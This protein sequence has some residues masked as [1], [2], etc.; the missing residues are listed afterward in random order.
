M[1]RKSAMKKAFAT[2]LTATLLLT[3]CTTV[4]DSAAS[5][6]SETE[7]TAS[8]MT[9]VET[10]ALFEKADQYPVFKVVIKGSF[11][12]SESEY[13]EN[14]IA[15]F[16]E[17][18]EVIVLKEYSFFSLVYTQDGLFGYVDCNN[19]VPTGE[20]K[21][22]DIDPSLVKISSR[23]DAVTALA[24]D[25]NAILPDDAVLNQSYPVTLIRSTDSN[26]QQELLPVLLGKNYKKTEDS[27]D[28]IQYE[29]TDPS[30]PNRYVWI[31]KSN[32]NLWFYDSMV[33][34]ERGGE[35]K[36]PSMNMTPE[37]SLPIAQKKAAE[38]L[39]EDRVFLPSQSWLKQ[40][41]IGY[42]DE[43][44]YNRATREDNAHVHLFE[45]QT[46]KG[47]NILD[48]GT[49]VR[50]GVNGISDL[51]IDCSKYAISD[52]TSAKPISLDEALKAAGKICYNNTTIV[53]YAELVY[54]NRVTGNDNFNLSW[55]LV[56][57]KGNYV[58]DC[59]TK[60]AV[61]D[62]YTY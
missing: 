32:G 20:Y 60:N 45:R 14:I 19:I 15:S 3:S 36:A 48:G 16:Q 59:V 4:N 27:D 55:Y 12:R 62:V 44:V 34:G 13:G 9:T 24:V 7:T 53:L 46:E 29:S 35:Y 1:N 61:C 39:G 33:T 52:S 2:V 50:I 58:V 30:M 17:G 40:L 25:S 38:I 51:Y 8:E 41:H 6:V 26:Y 43:T 42:G 11:L 49:K 57:N 10:T 22:L 47:I 54:S 5:S 23:E 28:Q 56:T 18:D 21:K 31:T 37:E